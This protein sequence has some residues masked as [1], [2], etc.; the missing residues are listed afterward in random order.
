MLA[1]DRVGKWRISCRLRCLAMREL[2]GTLLKTPGRVLR[3]TLSR[4][5]A[6]V[7]RCGSTQPAERTAATTD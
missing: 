5:D 2:E 1:T 4:P 3:E 6:I 7:R